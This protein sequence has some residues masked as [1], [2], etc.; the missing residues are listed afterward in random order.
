VNDEAERSREA[1]PRCGAH[2]LALLAFPAIHALPY[3]PYAEIIG[4]VEPRDRGVPGIG[5]L[6]CGAEWA[7]VEIFRAEEGPEVAGR[8]EA[9]GQRP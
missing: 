2:R 4:L 6:A 8:G 1:C 7:S 3:Q 9:G 5:C